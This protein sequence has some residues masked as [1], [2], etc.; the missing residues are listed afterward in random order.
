MRLYVIFSKAKEQLIPPPL[1]SRKCFWPN[2][3]VGKLKVTEKSIPCPLPLQLYRWRW[4]EMVSYPSQKIA[5]HT[6]ARVDLIS[7]SKYLQNISNFYLT[8]MSRQL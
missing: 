4:P 8:I 7:F 5:P 1:P 6:P 2:F 3:C